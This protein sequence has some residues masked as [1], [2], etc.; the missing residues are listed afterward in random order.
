MLVIITHTNDRLNVLA[1][2]WKIVAKKVQISLSCDLSGGG[3]LMR[4]SSWTSQFGFLL[5][6]HI[7]YVGMGTSIARLGEMLQRLLFQE[8]WLGQA[9]LPMYK[10]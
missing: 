4:E 8:P 10:E 5:L 7:A 3:A 2:S 6:W 1:C 9:P